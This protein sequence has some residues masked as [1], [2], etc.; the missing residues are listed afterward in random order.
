MDPD[1]LERL[2]EFA[3]HDGPIVDLPDVTIVIVDGRGDESV[4]RRL[5]NISRWHRRF[6]RPA[7]EVWFTPSEPMLDHVEWRRIDGWP[8]FPHDYSLWCLRQLHA[9]I[10]TSHVLIAQWDG[11]AIHPE[12]WKPEFI[13]CDYIGPPTWRHRRLPDR[14]R[15]NKDVVGNGGFSMRS[16][17]LAEATAS[18]TDERHPES[19]WEDVY[20]CIQLR[21]ELEQRGLRF[22]TED[23]GWHWGQNYYPEKPLDGRFG[24]HGNSLLPIVKRRLESRWIPCAG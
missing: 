7:A 11:F 18:L 17:R 9:E 23:L 21:P 8:N 22:A 10:A 16:K 12:H 2:D 3:P 19:P 20:L 1:P 13:Q 4:M 5:R 6:L 14:R 24:F 15:V